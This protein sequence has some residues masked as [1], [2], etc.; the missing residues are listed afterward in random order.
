MM[1]NL[2]LKYSTFA[3]ARRQIQD[4]ISDDEVD[5]VFKLSSLGIISKKQEASLKRNPVENCTAKGD[6]QVFLVKRE[7]MKI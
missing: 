6:P 4:I 3:D 1:M 7:A 5:W 2:P